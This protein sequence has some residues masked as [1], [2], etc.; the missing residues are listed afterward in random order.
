MGIIFGLGVL[1]G[2]LGSNLIRSGI[3]EFEEAVD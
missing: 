2:L 1:L 3:Q